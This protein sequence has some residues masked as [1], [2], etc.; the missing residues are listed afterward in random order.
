M[1]EDHLTPAPNTC[2]GVSTA[3]RRRGT[4]PHHMLPSQYPSARA[5]TSRG[6]KV[7][8][9]ELEAKDSLPQPGQ[10]LRGVPVKVRKQP[11]APCLGKLR[12]RPGQ[13]AELLGGHHGGQEAQHAVEQ[14]DDGT[15]LLW[16]QAAQPPLS[17]V[18]EKPAAKLPANPVFHVLNEGLATKVKGT[19]AVG[20]QPLHS[21]R[22]LRSKDS[23][24]R[25]GSTIPLFFRK[26]FLKAHPPHRHPAATAGATGSSSLSTTPGRGAEA[27]TAVEFGLPGPW[28]PTQQGPREGLPCPSPPRSVA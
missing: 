6:R 19:G 17:S 25:S 21:L 24:E 7:H 27:L 20:D 9:W 28:R 26:R 14:F 18:M 3:R 16:G 8:L 23:G 1:E 11:A 22:N 10:V 12:D 15:W 13:V 2:Q 4:R 5:R